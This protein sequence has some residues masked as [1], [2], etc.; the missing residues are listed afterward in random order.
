MTRDLGISQVRDHQGRLGVV[1]NP[2]S[3]TKA[4]W[5]AAFCGPDST[6]S[7]SQCHREW[8]TEDDTPDVCP[9]GTTLKPFW[10]RA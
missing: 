2:V 9:C 5:I 6:I 3:L 1:L 10:W 7:C 4:Q 8:P